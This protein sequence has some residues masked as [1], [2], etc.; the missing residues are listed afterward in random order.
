[1]SHVCPADGC[2]RTVPDDMLACRTHWFRVSARTRA[3]VWRAY[4]DGTPDH[5]SALTTAIAEMNAPRA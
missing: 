5:W 1:M 4:R 3:W 2:D